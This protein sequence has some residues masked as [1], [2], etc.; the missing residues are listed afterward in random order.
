MGLVYGYLWDHDPGSVLQFY[1]S[2]SG[3]LIAQAF[4]NNNRQYCV[5]LNPGAY[6]VKVKDC[7]YAKPK[8]YN[9]V[10]SPD[11][12][13][14]NHGTSGGCAEPTDKTVSV[15][16]PD[17]AFVYRP[18]ELVAHNVGKPRLN[19]GHYDVICQVSEIAW[20]KG[21][22]GGDSS[23]TECGLVVIDKKGLGP[24]EEIP[25]KPV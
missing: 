25:L 9:A 21:L 15:K 5:M 16:L 24:P 3:A 6:K 4:S 23:V 11:F 2:G 20:P 7:C 12:Q 19:P 13:A 8:D 18:A 17:N 1:D 22:A 10:L 14:F